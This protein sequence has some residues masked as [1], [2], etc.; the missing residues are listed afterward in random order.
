MSFDVEIESASDCTQYPHNSQVMPSQGISADCAHTSGRVETLLAELRSVGVVLSICAEGLAFDAPE[1]VLTDDMLARLR[2]DRDGMLR[3]LAEQD[4]LPVIE[5]GPESTTVVCP[6][7]RS[8]RLADDAEGVRCERCERLAWVV[9]D[10]SLIRSDVVDDS[11]DFLRPDDVDVCPRCG[12]LFDTVAAA[13][14]W[15][16]SRCEPQRKQTTARW[17]GIRERILSRS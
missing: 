1:N 14:G 12:D 9:I 6:W 15:A 4:L 7:C 8:D 10:S 3:L 13:G 17:L 2:A 11:V 5:S 16:C